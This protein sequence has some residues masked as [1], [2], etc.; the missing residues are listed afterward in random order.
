[1]F[2]MLGC[3][4]LLQSTLL[5]GW[6]WTLRFF[7]LGILLSFTSEYAGT[8][9][10]FV[11]G[12]FIDSGWEPF[13]ILG[14]VPLATPIS[15]AI[16]IYIS[17]NMTNLAYFGFGGSSSPSGNW[18][19]RVLLVLCLCAVDGLICMNSDMIFDPIMVSPQKRLWVW[20]RG[21]PYFDI[22]ISNFLGSF[23]V[24]F[25]ATFLVRI[26][27]I[28]TKGFRLIGNRAVH[29]LPVLAYLIICVTL[30][31]SAIR[32]GYPHYALI[33]VACM[34]PFVAVLA[35]AFWVRICRT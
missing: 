3:L 26:C 10:G 19:F 22:P 6:K 15:W 17:Y 27:E 16:L 13:L 33:G 12:H 7:S 29:Y 5:Y 4:L 35:V 24:G 23:L 30:S 9:W 31:G 11:F 32:L 1:M 28:R 34:A 2:L 8:N 14:A 20:T 25:I 21:G 18:F